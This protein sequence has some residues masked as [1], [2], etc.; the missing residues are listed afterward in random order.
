MDLIAIPKILVNIR[1]VQGKDSIRVH[2]N[3]R[4]KILDRGS[5][6]PGYGIV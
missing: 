1:K 6:L 4:V 2:C 5:D 3:N